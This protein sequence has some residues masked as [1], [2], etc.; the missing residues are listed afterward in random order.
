M[1]TE[2]E[3]KVTFQSFTSGPEP[4]VPQSNRFQPQVASL[5]VTGVM[6]A[7]F[8]IVHCNYLCRWGFFE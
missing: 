4:F 6:K 8:F 5:G 3:K 7:S 2:I 1:E